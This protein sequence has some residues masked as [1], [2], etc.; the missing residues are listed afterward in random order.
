MLK[1]TASPDRLAVEYP[2]LNHAD[3]EELKEF[4]LNMMGVVQLERFFGWFAICL[5]YLPSERLS[6]LQDIA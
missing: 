5:R 3:I 2:D 1:K 4:N 6:H